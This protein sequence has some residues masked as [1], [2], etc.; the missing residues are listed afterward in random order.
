MNGG[1]L[2]IKKRR[3]HTNFPHFPPQSQSRG[4]HAQRT[5]C[6]LGAPSPA[7]E[8]NEVQ[9]KAQQE[10]KEYMIMNWWRKLYKLFLTDF[11]SQVL[12]TE[13]SSYILNVSLKTLISILTENIICN[14]IVN[15]WT[16]GNSFAL[17]DK[18][19]KHDLTK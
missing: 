14:R 8:I 1:S 5:E 12:E 13:G 9:Q 3:E 7:G 17:S 18:T 10:Y 19:N 4:S 6:G 11:P 16:Q 15:E 2:D